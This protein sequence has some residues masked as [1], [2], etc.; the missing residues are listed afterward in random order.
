MN[1][2]EVLNFVLK[3]AR[4]L[5]HSRLSFQLNKSQMLIVKVVQR[6]YANKTWR[7]YLAT[8]ATTLSPFS[9]LHSL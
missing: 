1:A 3:L 5:S 4:F 7:Y 6:N 2:S 9:S 8:N